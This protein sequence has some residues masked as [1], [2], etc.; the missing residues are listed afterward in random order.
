MDEIALKQLSE[1]VWYL[2]ARNE[3]DRP[4]LGAVIGDN[5]TLIID[6]GNSP[7]HARLFLN[8]LKK[9]QAPESRL[10]VITHWHWDHIF[11]MKEMN[12]PAISHTKTKQ[13]IEKLQGLEW[14]D[15]ALDQRVEAGEEIQFCADMIKKEYGARRDQ[16][17]IVPPVITFEDELSI[18]LGGIKVKLIHVGGDHADDSIVVYVED[19]EILFLGDCYTQNMYAEKW[20]Y[21][22]PVFMELLKKLENFKASTYLHSHLTPVSQEEFFKEL[23]DYRTIANAVVKHKGDRT[24][25]H[26]ALRKE[27]GREPNSDDLE[28]SSFFDE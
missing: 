12:L 27:L 10:L 26:T 25:I 1:R 11:G 6:A 3:T 5:H 7:S 19:D 13:Y 2:P 17:E 24:A 21:N 9:L 28:F 14:S 15:E 4:V 16:I 22:Y 8:N 23:N 18:D 20:H